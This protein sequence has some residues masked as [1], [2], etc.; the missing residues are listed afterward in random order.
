M[1]NGLGGVSSLIDI[2][3]GLQDLGFKNINQQLGVAGQVGALGG[4]AQGLNGETGPLIGK[5]K[6]FGGGGALRQNVFGSGGFGNL[7]KGGLGGGGLER[8]LE[9]IINQMAAQIGRQ[10]QRE[11]AGQKK[12]FAPGI[13]QG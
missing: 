11:Q 6:R 9:I 7:G 8:L 12:F 4:F 1:A 10:E 2:V 13:S 5:P 3:G